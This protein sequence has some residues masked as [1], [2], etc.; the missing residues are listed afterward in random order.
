MS[1]LERR[2]SAAATGTSPDH[3]ARDIPGLAKVVAVLVVPRS[4][5]GRRSTGRQRRPPGRRRGAAPRPRRASS[6]RTSGSPPPRSPARSS[7]TQVEGTRPA[8]R[9]GQPGRSAS[10][11]EAVETVSPVAAPG[12]ARSR[13]TRC[14]RPARSCCGSPATCGPR[15]ASHPAYARIIEELAPD[16]GRILLLLL[17]KGPQATV[18]VRT[19]GL[20]G[21]GVLDARAGEP[22]HD[23]RRS[24]GAGT[25]SGCR[26]TCTT[27]SG[28][29]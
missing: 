5:P 25:S 7:A 27:S 14:T 20:V 9:R 24:P 28:S 2:R 19:G 8:R 15:T 18:D 21:H 29:G 17:R 6:P 13:S 4:A 26:R 23:R 22:Q 10:S 12:R 11:R 16:E 1:E 3:R